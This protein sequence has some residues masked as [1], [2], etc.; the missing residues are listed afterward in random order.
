LDLRRPT[1]LRLLTLRHNVVRSIRE[2][3]YGRDFLE[4]ETP[5][6]FKSTPEGARE[7][8]V[9]SRLN[10]GEFY[11]LPQSPQ[12]YKQMLMVAGIEKYFQIAK[13]FRD[14]DLRSDRQPEFTQVD[15]EASFV[16]REQIYALV[17]D[18]L[19]SVWS[20]VCGR[21]IA[22]P[23]RRISYTQAL[24]N[25]GTDKPDMRFELSLR[26]V[27]DLFDRSDFKIFR[28]TVQTGGV[29]KAMNA[30]ELGDITD[31][32]LRQ[33][34]IG[35]REAGLRG[36]LYAKIGPNSWKSP[37]ANALLQSEKDA[38]CERLDLRT[39]DLVIFA[40]DE[41]RTA[42]SGL[43]RLRL[44][45]ADLLVKKGRIH[46]EE[47]ALHFLW[48]TEFPLMIFDEKVGR[49][50]SAHHPFTAPVEE[51]IGRLYSAPETVRGQHYDCVLNGVELGGGSIRVHDSKLQETI[52]K[53][54]L[55]LDPSVVESRFGYMLRAFRY[56][57]PPHGGIALG[58][59]RLIAMLA[60]RESIRDVI[61]FPKNQRAQEPMTQSPSPVDP[62]QIRDLGIR[63]EV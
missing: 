55:K 17:E 6:L 7:F 52:F 21:Q 43:G 3:L 32:E 8:L 57:A 15:I 1:N 59:D 30:K 34:E 5:L 62:G 51:D 19:S 46:V 20:R 31:G 53:D 36:L 14:E 41:W 50:V 58:L 37:I 38:L 11:A 25:F 47:G 61:A 24:N 22:V 42:C 23:F 63:L 9:P 49:F 27:G 35:A 44:A 39:G 48:V 26:D 54:V 40:A 33:L 29:V 45:C 16:D 4:V 10:P 18:M 12:Q 28:S 56:G 13:C 60:G 2:Y